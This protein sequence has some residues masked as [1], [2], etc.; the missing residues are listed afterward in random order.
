MK[1]S[2]RISSFVLIVLACVSLDLASKDLAAQQL[3]GAEP[4]ILIGGLFRLQYVHNPG[5]FLSLGADLPA[6]VRNAL[7]IVISIGVGVV[8]TGYCFVSRSVGRLEVLASALVVAGGI[9]N[10]ID[11]IT[12]GAVRDFAILQLGSV[13]TGVFNVADVA[14][15]VGALLLLLQVIR[16][17]ETDGDGMSSA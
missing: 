8:L 2:V 6:P 10:S 12:I 14:I 5:A 4:I 15:T 3:S 13:R 16:S 1:R 7:F 11:R 17:S 9:G